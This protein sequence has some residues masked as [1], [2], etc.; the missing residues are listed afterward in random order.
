MIL[1]PSILVRSGL[2][3]LLALVLQTYLFSP[4]ELTGTVVWVLPASVVVFGLLGGSLT[5][6][7]AGFLVGLLSDA[8]TNSPLGSTAL[9]LM[10]AGY[11]AGLYRER[12]SELG[13]LAAGIACGLGTLVAN[14]VIGLLMAALG[15]SGP[16]SWGAPAELVVQALYGFLL[17][18]PIFLLFRKV[19]APG[20]VDDRDRRRRRRRNATARGNVPWEGIGD[21]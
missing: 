11:L 14:L 10:G 5:G 12:G 6:G 16:L 18:I 17:G 7:V 4:V 3:L 8:L 21:R 19:L 20:L 9:A 15:Q 2:L 13:W 1:T